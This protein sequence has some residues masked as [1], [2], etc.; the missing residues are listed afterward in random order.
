MDAEM[1]N[2]RERTL[3][4]L[5]S[6]LEGVSGSALECRYYPCHFEGQDC[7]FC[8]CPFYPCLIRETGGKLKG[9]VW[10]CMD[11][12]W[13]HEKENV[14]RII[15]AL[16]IYPR[17]RLVEEGWHFFNVILQNLLYG[18]ERGTWFRG[19]YSLL[20]LAGEDVLPERFLAVKIRNFQIVEVLESP[21]ISSLEDYVMIPTESPFQELG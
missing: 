13:V 5:F 17:Q 2:L 6:A 18:S 1:G 21:D 12:T 7:T 16:S 11:C 8:Y 3:K 9:K 14:E 15:E 4:E 19:N 10:S 20:D